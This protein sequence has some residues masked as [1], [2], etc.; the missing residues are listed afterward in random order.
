MDVAGGKNNNGS[1][2]FIDVFLI[3]PA[4][5]VFEGDLEL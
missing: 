2:S 4:K 1:D 3:G 5:M